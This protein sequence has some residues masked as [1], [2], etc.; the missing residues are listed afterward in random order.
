MTLDEKLGQLLM[1][2]VWGRFTSAGDPELR[3]LENWVTGGKVGGL[4]LQAF[5]T[6]AGIE[7][8]RVY[9]TAAL[10]NRLQSAA[11]IPLLV[12]ADF[13]TG[14]AMRLAEGTSLPHLM[15]V[16]ATGNPRDA[17][18]HGRIT[19]LEARAAGVNWIFAPVSDVNN[20]PA[21]PIINIRSFGEDP[22]KVGELA[23][24]FVHGAQA[25]GVLA[26]AK[27]F[28]GHGDTDVDSHMGL[29]V[30]TGDRE[31]LERVELAPF[32]A[33]IRA[34]VGSMMTGHLLVP[35]LEPNRKLPV[36]LS[37]TIIDGLLRRDMGFRGLVVTDSLDMAGVAM[38]YPANRT[39]VLSMQAGA[40]ILLL[41]PSPEA[42]LS[43]LR[44]AVREGR[45]A[46]AKIDDAVRRILFAKARLG[47]EKRPAVDLGRLNEA[48]G[49]PEFA[50]EALD[51]ADR[52]VTLL[53]DGDHLL[54]LDATRPA[55]AL[56][57]AISADPELLPGDGLENEIR[58]RVDSLEV[59]R[60]DARFVPPE[61]V[62]LPAAESYDVAIVALY[63]RVADRKGTIGLPEEQAKLVGRVLAAGKPVVV[64][65]FGSPYLI[66]HFPGARCWIAA[67][68]TTPVAERAMGRAIFGEVAIGGKL[69]VTVPGVAAMGLGLRVGANPMTLAA[70]SVEMEEALQPARDVLEQ[71]VNDRAFP[72]G[73]LAV[74]HEGRLIVHRFGRQTYSAKSP[75]VTADTIYDVASLTKVVV[76]TTAAMQLVEA[77]M[78]RL[79]APVTLYLPEW[80]EGPQRE[81]R[82]KVTIEDLLRHSS[83][84][85]AHREFFRKAK[86]YRSILSR[87]LAE[88]L[89]SEPG[90]RIVYSDL[91]FILL[92]EIVRQM[93][94]MS[95]DELA[96]ERI[97]RPLGMTASRFR[98]GRG[99]RARIAPTENDKTWRR[100]QVWG[101][102]HD[103]NAS[104]MGG[105]AGHAGLFSTTGDLAVFCQMLLNGG[106]Y[107]HRRLLERATI[108]RFT[109]RQTIG[110]AARALGWDVPGEASSCGRFFSRG[111]FGH[112]GFTGTSLWLDP[113][114]EL[115]VVLLTNRVYRSAEN[116]LHKKVRPALHD[117]VVKVLGL[118][119]RH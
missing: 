26:T 18:R 55:R 8:D 14:T 47:L 98:P 102:V 1:L 32:R 111:S 30:I 92:G 27:H 96:R 35:A 82:A 99:L 40:D 59:L 116:E 38:L 45:L 36:T 70:G 15:A 43:S 110:D 63:V 65:C 69:P 46:M 61:R 85:P 23:A 34:G 81:W 97:F 68:S 71:A 25:N 41:P 12:A 37:P 56:L 58:G 2:Y 115:F 95:L 62:E 114:K 117:A 52:G 73:V 66:S 10:L 7:I 53:R 104:A 107:A 17:Y 44:E 60:S 19:A 93:S 22:A 118:A 49:R 72:G 113:E 20:N 78:L 67:F 6:P 28:P 5:R 79:D 109:A 4:L 76:T 31:R 11:K 100:R 3:R 108:Q 103:Q 119:D 84:L 39:A 51:I 42:A 64:A 48:F 89:E 21:N 91:D 24:Q 75:A 29:P 83:G 80:V 74:G 13:E 112:T 94:G 90:T 77:G 88:P 86:G 33:A 101:E 106:S 9:P 87:V 50:R 16:A 105:V 57:V 54:P